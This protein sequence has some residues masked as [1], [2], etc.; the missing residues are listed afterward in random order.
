MRKIAAMAVRPTAMNEPLRVD[1]A[2]SKGVMG[3]PVWIGELTLG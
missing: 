2:P 3:G 1:A